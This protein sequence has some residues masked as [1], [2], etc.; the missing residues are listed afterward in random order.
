MKSNMMLT[1]KEGHPDR[2]AKVRK[3]AKGRDERGEKT[4]ICVFLPC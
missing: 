2:D 3:R 4:A 1:V